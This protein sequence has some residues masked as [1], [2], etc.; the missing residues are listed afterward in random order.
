MFLFIVLLPSKR[1]SSYASEALRELLLDP[2][3]ARII[4]KRLNAHD[5]CSHA[6]NG[7]HGIVIS[8]RQLTY[9]FVKAI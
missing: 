4:L 8:D 3:S 6:V 1:V 5:F 9:I 2:G 7:P